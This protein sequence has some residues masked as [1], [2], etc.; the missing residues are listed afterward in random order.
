[1]IMSLISFSSLGDNANATARLARRAATC[2]VLVD[3]LD[4]FHAKKDRES[5]GKL[6]AFLKELHK[7]VNYTSVHGYGK[8]SSK[9]KVRIEN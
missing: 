4:A 3:N 6:V 7:S 8:E 2:V 9:R 5:Q 1:M